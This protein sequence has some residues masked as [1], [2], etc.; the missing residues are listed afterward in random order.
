MSSSMSGDGDVDDINI[1]LLNDGGVDDNNDSN[2][3]NNA[4]VEACAPGGNSRR[5]AATMMMTNGESSRGSIEAGFVIVV[6]K[7]MPALRDIALL[8]ADGRAR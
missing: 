8:F 5:R 7:I 2:D 1:I 4:D 3:L 6:V